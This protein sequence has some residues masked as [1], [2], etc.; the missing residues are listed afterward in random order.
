MVIL[1]VLS[2]PSNR[3]NHHIRRQNLRQNL[4]LRTGR[5]IHVER[6]T[7][8]I[9]GAE[10]RSNR[11]V[12][13]G[14]IAFQINHMMFGE[15]VADTGAVKRHTFVDET[16]N[17]PC[18]GHVDKDWPAILAQGIKALRAESVRDRIVRACD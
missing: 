5:E 3:T 6:N 17:A 9:M 16:S 4:P 1:S 12:F 13:V 7:I 15:S 18:S 11:A 10:K 14:P 8:P 2:S